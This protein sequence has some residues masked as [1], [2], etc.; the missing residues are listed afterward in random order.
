MATI[1][2]N[3]GP[4]KQ[5]R[6]KCIFFWGGGGAQ[7]QGQKTKRVAF[8]E[9]QSSSL[10]QMWPTYLSIC[11]EQWNRTTNQVRL[12][13][14][15]IVAHKDTGT[16]S[17][18]ERGRGRERERE[19]ERERERGRGREGERERDLFVLIHSNG[20]NNGFGQ[21]C[22]HRLCVCVCVCVCV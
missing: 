2:S 11:H 17:Q 13:E 21:P 1:R 5:T 10:W 20:A 3:T 7:T 6:K 9:P 15:V 18:R 4:V 8:N 19:G 16:D 14:T 12:F 22:A